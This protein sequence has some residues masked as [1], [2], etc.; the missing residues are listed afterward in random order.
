MS[1]PVIT[2]AIVLHRTPRALIESALRALRCEPV[3]R[4]YLIDN[5]PDKSLADVAG[6]D[7]RAVYR[8]VPNRGYGNA[9]NL[10]ARM[11][12]DYGSDYHLVLNPDVRW[13]EPVLA[14]LVG[15]M[16][17]HDGCRLIQPRICNPDGSLQHTCR[18]LPTPLDVFIRGFLPSWMFRKRR[19]NYLLPAAAYD[20]EFHPVY[21]QGSFML[22]DTR[23]LQASDGFDERFFM[24]PED[25]DI[26]RRFAVHDTTLYT[27]EVTI[28]HDHA[29]SSKRLGR[30]MWIHAVNMCRYFNKWGWWRDAGRRRMNR[31]LLDE[32]E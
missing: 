2:V 28:V 3:S 25:I 15:I 5:S 4:I 19:S 20:R 13:E 27:P 29:A 11:A 6:A 18:L 30:M 31:R 22:F 26:T 8:H 10:A 14:R 1:D 17:A 7:T 23:A 32:V 16:R 24:Y 12:A 21:M 9:H